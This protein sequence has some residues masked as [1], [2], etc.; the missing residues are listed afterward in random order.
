MLRG[1]EIEFF[2]GSA[3]DVVIPLLDGDEQPIPDLT[4]WAG[5]LQV[6]YG[7]NHPTVLVEWGTD[8]EPNNMILAES[9]A[10]LVV[11]SALATASLDWTFRLARWD[12][13]L[14]APAG[15][16]SLPNRPIRGVFRVVQGITR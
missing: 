1:Q 7:Y 16:G 12:L 9:A 2:T 6:R 14:T 4:G 3:E 15:Q 10:R 5:R 13:R 8:G 11:D